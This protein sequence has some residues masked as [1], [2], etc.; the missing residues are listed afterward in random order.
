[1]Q[2]V[3]LTPG[4]NFINVFT[5]SFYACRSQKRKIDCQVK[6]LFALSGSVG[7]KAAIKCNMSNSGQAAIF[8]FG[9]CERKSCH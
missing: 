4:V 6:R 1:M 7:V 9:I 5:H 2:Y 3:K 8:A